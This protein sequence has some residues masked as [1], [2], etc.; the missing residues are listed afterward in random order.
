[1]WKISSRKSW[2]EDLETKHLAI[3]NRWWDIHMAQMGKIMNIWNIE[4]AAKQSWA[5]V[6]A[7]A[8]LFIGSY[9]TKIGF[10]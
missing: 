9:G 7:S 1:M 4:Y 8:C 2:K 5:L 6:K 3:V 10:P